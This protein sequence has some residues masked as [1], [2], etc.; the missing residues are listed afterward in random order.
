MTE[1]V[2]RLKAR[3]T[4][5]EVPAKLLPSPRLPLWFRDQGLRCMA[6]RG[7][8]QGNGP[9]GAGWGQAGQVS[10][11]AGG[12]M[13]LTGDLYAEKPRDRMSFFRTTLFCGKRV[14]AWGRGEMR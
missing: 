4:A 12:T 1:A 14:G 6:G 2:S 11:D 5:P 10:P 9:G 13:E 7:S 3:R 8:E